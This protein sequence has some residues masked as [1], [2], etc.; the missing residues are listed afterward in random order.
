MPLKHTLSYFKHFLADKKVASITPCSQYTVRKLCNK[1][2]Y[3]TDKVIVEFGPGSGGFTQYMLDHMTNHSRLITIE[4]NQAFIPGLKA[5]QSQDK[6]LSVYQEDA[7]HLPWILSKEGIASV[8]YALSGIPFSL[9]PTEARQ[10]IVKH[11]CRHLKPGGTFLLY[12]TSYRMVKTLRS[13]F[14][15]VAKDFELRNVPPMYLMEA[16]KQDA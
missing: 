13:Y 11:T 1:I 8:D 6:R 4:L 12:Q 10:Q 16:T 14:D 5:M 9:I 3:S 7:Q 2:D 15:E